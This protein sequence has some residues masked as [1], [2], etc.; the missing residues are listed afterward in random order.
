MGNINTK[1]LDQ[2]SGDGKSKKMNWFVYF[3]QDGPE[4]AEKCKLRFKW[5]RAMPV[6]TQLFV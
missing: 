5:Q 6:G 4:E 2:D 3:K 1:Y